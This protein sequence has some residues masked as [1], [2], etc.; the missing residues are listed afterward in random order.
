ML[1]AVLLDARKAQRMIADIAGVVLFLGRL[2]GA[3]E[4]DGQCVV[5]PGLCLF[6]GLGR[7]ARAFVLTQG[8]K[9]L[10]CQRLKSGCCPKNRSAASFACLAVSSAL[11]CSASQEASCFSQTRMSPPAV[12]TAARAASH[13]ALAGLVLFCKAAAASGSRGTRPAS[14]PVRC[15][16]RGPL[17]ARRGRPT[18]RPAHP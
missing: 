14:A 15:S 5:Q 13:A 11:V 2:E 18:A 7:I 6:G 16:R 12:S 1:G 3:G 10:P 9:A 17:P 4:V 8:R